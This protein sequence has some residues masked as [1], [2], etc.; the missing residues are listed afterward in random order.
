MGGGQQHICSPGLAARAHPQLEDTP[1]YTQ[2]DNHIASSG[3]RMKDMRIQTFSIHFGFKHKFLASDV[4]FA[5]MSLM[6][7][8]EKD[9]SGT[10]NFIQA[11]DSLSR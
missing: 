2:R 6:E 11:L 5:T 3:C 9:S 10:D 7:S 1:T 4:V 8:P